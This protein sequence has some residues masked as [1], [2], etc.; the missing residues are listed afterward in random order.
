MAFDVMSLLWRYPLL[1]PN[2]AWKH[3]ARLKY[4]VYGVSEEKGDCKASRVQSGAANDPL[5]TWPSA[6]GQSEMPSGGPGPTGC[7]VGAGGGHSFLS[8]GRG[9]GKIS[10]FPSVK[11]KC[12]I[13]PRLSG[14][15]ED[16]IN[17]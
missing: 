17:I 2:R 13:P 11:W 6:S 15:S 4:R 12:H 3:K 14:S 9:S 8:L 16:L 1:G 5:G 7:P 10:S